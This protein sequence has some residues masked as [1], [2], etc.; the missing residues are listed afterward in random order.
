M[1]HQPLVTVLW[2][3]ELLYELLCLLPS[4]KFCR[5]HI[6][7][8]MCLAGEIKV[9][10]EFNFFIFI[11]IS[12]RR[13]RNRKRKIGWELKIN[14][15]VFRKIVL[16]I[17]LKMWFMVPFLMQKSISS[18]QVEIFFKCQLNKNVNLQHKTPWSEYGSRFSLT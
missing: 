3:F 7:L 16:F 5:Q 11:F 6:V 4:Y 14:V 12:C 17:V 15:L 2:Y 9:L 18:I 1:E 13:Q 8:V 10:V